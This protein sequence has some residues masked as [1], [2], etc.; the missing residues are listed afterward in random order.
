VAVAQITPTLGAPFQD[1]GGAAAGVGGYARPGALT[2]AQV[3]DAVRRMRSAPAGVQSM[4]AEL[5]AL[6][7]SR[8]SWAAFVAR[9]PE[10]EASIALLPADHREGPTRALATIGARLAVPALAAVAEE[11]Q[12][13]TTLAQWRAASNRLAAFDGAAPASDVAA[14]RAG[15]QQRR[16]TLV[17]DAVAAERQRLA[18]IDAGPGG[19]EAMAAWH[20]DALG[21]LDEQARGEA[22]VQQLMRD[23]RARRDQQ[24]AA[25]LPTLAARVRGARSA[26]EIGTTLGQALAVPGDAESS[27]G[28][29]LR[30][31]APAREEQLHKSD[32]L[33][34]QAQERPSAP[35]AA[36]VPAAA[37]TA[38]AGTSR[39][40]TASEMY[41]LIQARFNS[42]AEGVRSAEADCRRGP[43]ANDPVRNVMCLGALMQGGAGAGQ[44]MKITKFEKLGCERASGKPGYVCDYILG[45]SGGAT[46]AAGPTMAALVG[47]GNAG[48][49]RF[50]RTSDGWVAFFGEK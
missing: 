50:L 41:D 21:R 2:A 6:P 43:S 14:V 22:D 25:A 33:G 46:G 3:T 7:P 47:R 45:Y 27:P 20:R 40:P 8:D 24:L 32:V 15:L 16:G 44:P 4:L 39:E 1:I 31:L 30:Q 18:A 29:E 10:V 34:A 13:A 11:A 26:A 48:Q 19:L 35:V 23:F 37:V 5:D 36:A 12:A 17:R 38:T 28:R 49:A 9:R 42:V